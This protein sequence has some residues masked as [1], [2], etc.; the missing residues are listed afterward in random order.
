MNYKNENRNYVITM[1]DLSFPFIKV[2]LRRPQRTGK[3]GT[4]EIILGG[5][6]WKLK[7]WQC[8]ELCLYPF[9]AAITR[10]NTLDDL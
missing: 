7:L 2:C 3:E 8:L 1:R 5:L 4:P 9:Q 10:H 6:S